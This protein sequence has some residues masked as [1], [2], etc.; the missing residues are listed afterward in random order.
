MLGE[1]EVAR[2]GVARA[3]VNDDHSLEN[4]DTIVLANSDAYHIVYT[5]Y[6]GTRGGV[7]GFDFSL[8]GTGV[9]VVPGDVTG[10]RAQNC[11]L[12]AKATQYKY[13]SNLLRNNYTA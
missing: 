8:H 13:I 11:P 10:S 7:I 5:L 6:L 9:G 1:V 3:T 2:V 4:R 12:P